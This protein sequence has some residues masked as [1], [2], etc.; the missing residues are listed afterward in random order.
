MESLLELYNYL[1]INQDLKNE[2]INNDD[3]HLM[4]LGLLDD[5]IELLAL[6]DKKLLINVELKDLYYEFI[7][8]EKYLVNSYGEVNN[9]LIRDILNCNYDN[10]FLV[11]KN[12]INI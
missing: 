9:Y 5:I 2:L 11:V 3:N 1:L 7:F 8:I 4:G 6:I 12:M 10:L